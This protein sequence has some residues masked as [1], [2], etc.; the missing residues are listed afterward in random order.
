MY[1]LGLIYSFSRRS[2]ACKIQLI[3][4][5]AL[6]WSTT[7]QLVFNIYQTRTT[8]IYMY[9][10]YLMRQ[11]LRGPLPVPLGKALYAFNGQ[12]C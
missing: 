2:L 4:T 5:R 10:V 8:Y 1:V 12:D 11:S 9:T 6:V 3:N 7:A